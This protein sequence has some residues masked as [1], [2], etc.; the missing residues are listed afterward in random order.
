M[1]RGVA[2]RLAHG[3]QDGEAIPDRAATCQPDPNGKQHMG[4]NAACSFLRLPRGA[5]A[6]PDPQLLSMGG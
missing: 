3:V 4:T 1:G 5:A 6:P 2:L